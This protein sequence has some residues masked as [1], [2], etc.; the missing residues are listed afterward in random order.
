ML[1]LKR[2][3]KRYRKNKYDSIHDLSYRFPETGFVVLTGPSGAG[4]STLLD[5]ISGSDTKFSGVMEFDG[6][7]IQKSNIE[8]YRKEFVSVV[9]QDL[10]L[11]PSLS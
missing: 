3:T 5:I 7:R 4:K 6:I 2:I 1:E 10:N 8:I 11:I 9:F